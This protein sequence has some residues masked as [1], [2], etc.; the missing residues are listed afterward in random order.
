LGRVAT[1]N[2]VPHGVPGIVWGVNAVLEVASLGLGVA[3]L[4][5][6]FRLRSVAFPLVI[7]AVA[8]GFMSGVAYDVVTSYRRHAVLGFYMVSGIAALAFVVLVVGYVARL[9]Q[10]GVLE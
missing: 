4:I 6:L 1:L 9:R 2:R 8:T 3:A 5:E 10:T 7:A